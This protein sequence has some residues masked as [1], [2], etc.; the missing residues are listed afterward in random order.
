MAVSLRTL[1][2][3]KEEV[4]VDCPLV[5]LVQDDHRVPGGGGEGEGK[6]S[7]VDITKTC[8]HCVLHMYYMLNKQ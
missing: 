7:Y 1:A 8:I 2:H 3:P 6:G 4:C 5:C